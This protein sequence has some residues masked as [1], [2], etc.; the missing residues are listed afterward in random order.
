MAL[1]AH[2]GTFTKGQKMN[3]DARKDPVLFERP[4][5]DGGHVKLIFSFL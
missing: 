2:V 1:D 4:F 3:Y 5:S